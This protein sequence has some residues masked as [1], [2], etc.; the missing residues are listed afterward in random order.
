MVPTEW[1]V[2][3]IEGFSDFCQ[4]LQTLLFHLQGRQSQ[5]M[6]AEMRNVSP[7]VLKGCTAIVRGQQ[8]SLQLAIMEYNLRLGKRERERESPAGVQ[9]WMGKSSWQEQFRSFG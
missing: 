8:T 6:V 2:T 7:L 5:P 3:C 1:L 4:K 9:E